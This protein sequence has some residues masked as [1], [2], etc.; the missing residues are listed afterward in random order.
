MAKLMNHHDTHFYLRSSASSHAVIQGKSE[1]DLW[2]AYVAFPKPNV[3][4]VATDKDYLREVLARMGGKKAE[5]ALPDTLAEWKHVNTHAQF[6]AVRHYRKIGAEKDPTSPFGHC[7]GS[8]PDDKAIGLTFS[9]DAEKSATATVTYLSADE[10]SLQRF[11]KTY[12]AEHGPALTEMHVRY[13]EPEPSA[14]EGSYDLDQIE[15]GSYFVFVL[16]A[17]LGHAIYL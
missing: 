1:E 9:F 7:P 13:W 14:V 11:Q 6:W 16:A 17:L 8:T 4:V 10:N 5:R 15:S 3:A 12:F 2:T